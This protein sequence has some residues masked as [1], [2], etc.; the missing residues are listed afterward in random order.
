MGRG[1]VSLFP[2]FPNARRP[3]GS[4]GPGALVRSS[5]AVKHSFLLTCVSTVLTLALVG[6]GS[7][8]TRLLEKT[9]ELAAEGD[10]TAQFNLALLYYY[11]TGI[12]RDVAQAI[13][14]YESAGEQGHVDAQFYLGEAYRAGDGVAA[15][16]VE[17]ADWYRR[18]GEQG[19]AGAQYALARMYDTGEGLAESKADAE[20]WYRLAA[21]Q[22][23]A[24]AQFHLGYLYRYG[25]GVPE[26]HVE[27]YFWWELARRRNDRAGQEQRKLAV[28]TDAEGEFIMGR[29]LVEE[30]KL[31]ADKWIEAHPEFEMRARS[32]AKR[33]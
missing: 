10:P 24:D 11:G 5:R 33:Q 13:S 25:L 28:E 16:P 14:W 22:G 1:S 17:A 15:D 8:G 12:E 27:A 30:A 7:S 2:C 29:Y 32:A 23:H 26:D 6:C 18:A 4:S 19:H 3:L 9:Q 21:D 31:R 20:R